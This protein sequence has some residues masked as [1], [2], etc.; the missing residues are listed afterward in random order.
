MHVFIYIYMFIHVYMQFFYLSIRSILICEVHAMGLE[1]EILGLFEPYDF[2]GK[3]IGGK[4]FQTCSSAGG[5]LAE[6]LA[7]AGSDLSTVIE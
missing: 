5:Q 6:K 3:G 2:H 7:P 1:V 4:D